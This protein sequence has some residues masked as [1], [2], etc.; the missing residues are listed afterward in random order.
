MLW[1]VGEHTY[2][3][4]V[5]KVWIAGQVYTQSLQATNEN[6][7][8]KTMQRNIE[9]NIVP[10]HDRS[11]VGRGSILGLEKINQGGPQRYH[12]V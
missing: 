11:P 3:M 5:D 12:N 4:E 8:N 2:E 1:R 9:G 6:S 10:H 7:R